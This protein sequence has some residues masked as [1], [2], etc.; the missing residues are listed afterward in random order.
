MN[1]MDLLEAVT[2]APVDARIML[3]LPNGDEIPVTEARAH[4]Q[5]IVL[6]ADMEEPEPLDNSAHIE[7]AMAQFPAEDFLETVLL[8][9]RALKF[10]PKMQDYKDTLLETLEEIQSEVARAAEYGRA[11]LVAALAEIESE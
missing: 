8:S 10:P 5:L 2:R 11:E 7:E 6:R 3:Q 1:T 4:C 9:I